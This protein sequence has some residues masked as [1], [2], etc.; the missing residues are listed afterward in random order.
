MK[1]QSFVMAFLVVSALILGVLSLLSGLKDISESSLIENEPFQEQASFEPQDFSETSNIRSGITSE[2]SKGPGVISGVVVPTEGAPFS[3]ETIVR[4]LQ[5]SWPDRL[6]N[7]LKFNLSNLVDSSSFSWNQSSSP[8]KKDMRDVFSEVT[9]MSC[10]ADGHFRFEGLESGSYLVCAGNQQGI[11]S[12]AEKRVLLGEDQG[13][14]ANC[15]I[16]LQPSRVISVQVLSNSEPVEEARVVVFGELVD[17]T[18]L[19]ES[20]FISPADAWLYLLNDP[21]GVG[22]TDSEGRWTTKALPSIPYHIHAR[23]SVGGMAHGYV[24]VDATE[25]QRLELAVGG[26]LAGLVV[27]E[28]GMPVEGARVELTY[29]S[30]RPDESSNL[31]DE[32]LTDSEGLFL[33]G[34]LQPGEY[35][36]IVKLAGYQDE[37][38]Y[39]LLVLSDRELFEEITLDFGHIISGRLVTPLGEP[40]SGIP[41]K[42][43]PGLA[44]DVISDEQGYFLFDTLGEREFRVQVLG[45]CTLHSSTFTSVDVAPLEI[46]VQ[47]GKSFSGR[48][49]DSEGQSISG[50]GVQIAKRVVPQ[51]LDRYS[52]EISDGAG[53]FTVCS[54]IEA[55]P[56]DPLS[57]LAYS[58]KYE[59]KVFDLTETVSDLGDLVLVP[60]AKVFGKTLAPDGTPVSGAVV[61]IYSGKG[62]DGDPIGVVRQSV[63]SGA[64][65]QYEIYLPASYRKWQINAGHSDFI[66]SEV[67]EISTGEPGREIPLDLTL[68]NGG[69]LKISV[70]S[71]GLPIEGAHVQLKRSSRWRWADYRSGISDSQGEVVFIGLDLIK[72]SLLVSKLHFGSIRSEVDLTQGGTV[73]EEVSLDSARVLSGFVLS[74]GL[75]VPFA[76]VN[77]R[78][79]SG[80]TRS[81]QTE[82]DG[83]FVVDQL[84]DGALRVDVNAEGYLSRRVN[85]VSLQQSPLMISLERSHTLE[86]MIYERNTREPISK[87]LIEFSALEGSGGSR[88]V[89]S[90]RS[91]ESG[92]FNRSNLWTGQFLIRVIANDYLQYEEE[93]SVPIIGNLLEIPLEKGAEVF[94]KVS[95][96]Q[97]LPISGVRVAPYYRNDTRGGLGSWVKLKTSKRLYSNDLG[98]LNIGGLPERL[99]RFHITHEDYLNQYPTLNLTRTDQRESL[100]V[101]LTAGAV[102]YGTVYLPNG[103]GSRGEELSCVGISGAGEGKSYNLESK[104]NGLFRFSRLPAGEYELR[105]APGGLPVTV[106]VQSGQSVQIDL[107]SG[108]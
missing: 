101:T 73:I 82:E 6:A 70:T 74:D 47:A 52:S 72:Y 43:R 81:S 98:E 3:S 75:P 103:A 38:V 14:Q 107:D 106:S 89:R 48:F 19:P 78:D 25:E 90:V 17:K 83:S 68:T 102:I 97:G 18:A 49:V 26:A 88:R 53:R 57:L 55:E 11:W 85:G 94:L 40:V 9:R 5:L 13:W 45:A 12:P 62:P 28:A 44:E 7:R 84:T 41:I 42:I 93:I 46:V 31:E 61:D 15:E 64:S 67:L 91:D 1:L 108:S 23:H 35:E 30:G 104:R 65:G 2:P 4:L 92:F 69:T 86:G 39:D 24:S 100:R 80:T 8:W 36:L 95:D 16:P 87:A 37:K 54:E 33:F 56:D 60:A 50:V 21:F 22:L 32:V 77:V 27:D 10:S 96:S 58:E 66:S 71:G 79:A 51:L 20:L 29:E 34:A 99:V 105:A 76:H 59:K 63:F